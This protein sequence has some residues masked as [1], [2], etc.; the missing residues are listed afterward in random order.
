[1]PEQAPEEKVSDLIHEAARTANAYDFISNLP[2]GFQA[3]VGERGTL[4]SGGQKQRIAIARAVVSNPRILLL[5]EATAALDT[6]SEALVRTALDAASKGRTTLVIAHRLSTIRHADNIVVLNAGKLVEQ[7]THEV[8]MQ[9]QGIYHSLVEAQQVGSDQATNDIHFQGGVAFSDTDIPKEQ[10]RAGTPPSTDASSLQGEVP[11]HYSLWELIKFVSSL[12]REEKSRMALG[13]AASLGTGAGYPILAI[14]FGNSII[15]LSDPGSDTGGHDINFWCGMFLML[16]LVNFLLYMIQGMTFAWA[17]SRLISRARNLA[18]RAMLRQD[19]TFFDMKENTA[20]ALA[21]V[22]STEA[23]L[24]AGISGATLGA[25]LNFV[26]TIIGAIAV[27]CSFGWKLALVCTSTMPLLLACGFLRTWVLSD[28]EKRN[29]RETEA[30]GFACEAASAIRTVASLRLEE[31]VCRR[32]SQ[33]LGLQTRQDL[34]STLLSSTLYA[35]SQSLFFFASGL[36][37]WYGGT[38]IVK[39]EYTVKRFFICFVAVIWGSQAAG[40]IF[41]YAGDM[42]NARAAAARVKTLLGRIPSI[43]S[44]SPEGT[45]IPPKGL[46]GRIDFRKVSFSYPTRP[47][48]LVLRDLN[49]T[50]EPGQFIALVGASGCGKS[51]V[52]AL[53]E[54]FYSPGSGSVNIDD[55]DVSTYRIQDYRSQLALVH[56]ETT[57]HMGTIKENILADKEDACDEAIVQ[58]CKDANIYDFILSL[59]EGF[60][61]P[62]GTKGCLLSGGQKQRIAIAKALLRN[63]QILLLDE[64]TSALDSTS[65]ASVQAALDRAAKGRTTVAVAHRLSTIQ[66]A[67]VIY[68][69]DQGS[70]VERGSHAEL[71]RRG[72]RY[73]ELVRLQEVGVDKAKVSSEGGEA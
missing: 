51:T 31:E 67:D 21:S 65:E 38:L 57:L 30:A 2:G 59:P 63:P 66:H 68:V 44:W 16:G 34:W 27:S 15:A 4:L 29:R 24:I 28:L 10:E 11:K 6:K 32:Y 8:L 36:A 37:F 72:G 47:G 41:S 61:T 18:F 73:A 48:R 50:A 19:M 20:G 17:S 70:V 12:N 26:V 1:M 52:I 5:D 45:V 46:R 25:L 14:F 40:A 54:R 43:D 49:I 56:Q 53:L 3:R 69:L 55:H 62:V 35:M 39:G 58:A 7:G 9:K 13:F 64:A 23:T 22:L 71:M 33:M 60:D 42:S